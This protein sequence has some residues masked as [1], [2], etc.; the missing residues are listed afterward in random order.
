MKKWPKL[1]L[2]KK[3]ELLMMR[4]NGMLASQIEALTGIPRACV[5]YWTVDADIPRGKKRTP[6]K[7]AENA[8]PLIR[9]LHDAILEGPP[10][11]VLAS[12]YGVNPG[13]VTRWISA[14]TSPRLNEIEGAL[15]ALGYEVQYSVVKKPSARPASRDCAS[16]TASAGS[17]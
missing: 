10:M 5:L 2:E 7:L 16:P 9:A 1:T 4:E 3:R 6:M 13:T 15:S 17:P 14:T 12:A 8:H 11:Y